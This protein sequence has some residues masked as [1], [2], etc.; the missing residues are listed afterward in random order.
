MIDIISFMLLL[1]EK[2]TREDIKVGTK[3]NCFEILS[4][5]SASL[6]VDNTCLGE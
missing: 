1:K 6:R 3:S 4:V 2:R 5:F